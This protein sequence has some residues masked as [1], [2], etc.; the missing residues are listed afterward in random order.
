MDR[1]NAVRADLPL[2]L[3]VKYAICHIYSGGTEAVDR[4]LDEL[5][6]ES[7]ATYDDLYYEVAEAF[8]ARE[9]WSRALLFYEKA[10]RQTHIHLREPCTT[11]MRHTPTHTPPCLRE[12][13]GSLISDRVRHR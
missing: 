12:K 4:H 10:A 13:V 7:V 3:T 9:M 5:L 11:L 6:A 1:L 2:D 8:L